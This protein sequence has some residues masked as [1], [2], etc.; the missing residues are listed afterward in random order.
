LVEFYYLWK[1]TPGA[2]QNRPHR[3]RRQGSLRR[4]RNTR[5]NSNASNNNSKKEEETP[6]PVLITESQPSSIS[7]EENSSVTED[8]ISECDSDSSTTNK[9]STATSGEFGGS[10]DSPSRMRTRNKQTKEQLTK[11]R[12]KRNIDTPDAQQQQTDVTKMTPSKTDNLSRKNS[13]P[14]TLNKSKKRANESEIETSGYN[15]GEDSKDN[16]GIVKRKRVDSPTESLTTDSRPGSVLDEA[17]SNSE[18]LEGNSTKE[19]EEKDPLSLP[20]SEIQLSIEDSEKIIDTD[21]TLQLL[22]TMIAPIAQSFDL[23]ETVAPAIT[24]DSKFEQEQQINVS[25]QNTESV[26]AE[27]CEIENTTNDQIEEKTITTENEQVKEQEMLS[28]LAN[29]K[30]EGFSTGVIATK[31]STA[32]AENATKEIVFIKN[33]PGDDDSINNTNSNEPHDLKL[34]VEIKS[35]EKSIND[36]VAQDGE[37]TQPTSNENFLK[38]DLKDVKFGSDIK[39]SGSPLSERKSGKNE[40]EAVNIKYITP[41]DSAKYNQDGQVEYDMK[42]FID[43]NVGDSEKISSSYLESVSN[44]MRPDNTLNTN[45]PRY[46][47]QDCNTSES[48]LKYQEDL[49][50]NI[51]GELAATSKAYHPY[52]QQQNLLRQT[53]ENMKFDQIMKYGLPSTTSASQ[54]PDL[55][56]LTPEQQQQMSMLKYSSGDITTNFN[57]WKKLKYFIYF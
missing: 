52:D 20:T 55:K 18:I 11:K 51:G 30:Q 25:K 35:E 19:N 37:N 31:A 8:D 5:T 49:K 34:K 27:E 50:S 54:I 6:E 4:I 39:F 41:P 42:G 15:V 45:D 33:E 16:S 21:E 40:H 32:L 23:K 17:E 2:N 28:K 47:H 12:A 13:K 46:Y 43:Q 26:T 56:Y 9:G 29:M 44:S 14:E 48:S 36:I 1:K 7:K 3:R 38:S 53:Y 24:T 10:D 57:K 22:T